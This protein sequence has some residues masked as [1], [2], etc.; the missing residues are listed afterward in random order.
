[1]LARRSGRGKR[2]GLTGAAVSIVLL[3][4]AMLQPTAAQRAGA[5]PSS[6][7]PIKLNFNTVTPAPVHSHGLSLAGIAS[8]VRS[9]GGQ[10]SAGNRTVGLTTLKAMSSLHGAST[11]VKRGDGFCVYLTS[12]QVDFGW[13]DMQ[14]YVPSDYQRGSCEYRAVLDHENEHVA[15]I[16]ATLKEFAPRARARIESALAQTKPI[17]VRGRN[18]STEQALAPLQAQL[19]M[20]LKDFDALHSARSARIDHPS[21]YAAVTAMCKNWDGPLQK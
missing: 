11:L 5:C 16:R 17:L 3:L 19:S 9:G 10:A 2:I 21:N 18:G 6:R 1:M 12:V 4:C 7:T 20:L 8:M 14:V 15:I 13:E